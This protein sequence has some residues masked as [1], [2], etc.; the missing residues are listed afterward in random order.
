MNQPNLRPAR[1]KVKFSILAA[2]AEEV[3]QIKEKMQELADKLGPDAVNM[4]FMIAKKDPK[5]FSEMA[6]AMENVG[7]LGPLATIA[8]FVPRVMAIFE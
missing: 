6:T 2:D 4:I 7:V 1:I 5:I 8:P 3:R